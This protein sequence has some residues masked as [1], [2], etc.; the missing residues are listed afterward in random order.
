MKASRISLFICQIVLAIIV[1]GSQVVIAFFPSIPSLSK[2]LPPNP[3]HRAILDLQIY[4]LGLHFAIL[5]AG[6]LGY[7]IL[8]SFKAFPNSQ[9]LASEIADKLTKHFPRVVVRELTAQTFYSDFLQCVG[10]AV[11]TVKITYL[12]NEPPSPTDHPYKVDYYTKMIETMKTRQDITF[13]RLVRKSRQNSPW[14][15]QLIR[16]LDG[17]PNNSIALVEDPNNDSLPMALSVQVVDTHSVWFV[18]IA[19]HHQ[20]GK[21]RD[22]HIEDEVVGRMM[23][24]YYDRLWAKA[25][26]LLENGKVTAEGREHLRNNPAASA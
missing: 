21:F 4:F 13:K 2:T 20:D 3:D 11:H 22:M 19:S 6:L 7:F 15:A 1:V 23:N 24:I 16:E 12:D 26:K 25:I 14:V 8:E 5:T 17:K 9:A 10:K 18:A